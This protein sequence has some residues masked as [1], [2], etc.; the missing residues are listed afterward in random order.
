MYIQGHFEVVEEIVGWIRLK[1]VSQSC[2]HLSSEYGLATVDT[3][4]L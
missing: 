4:K 2:Q 1:L 3:V